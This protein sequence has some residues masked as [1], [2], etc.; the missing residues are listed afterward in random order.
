MGAQAVAG[1]VALRVEPSLQVG[2]AMTALS[3]GRR[4]AFRTRQ[5]LARKRLVLRT[6]P[7]M[8]SRTSPPAASRICAS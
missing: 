1:R 7:T 3:I 6:R 4:S 5:S 2:D 8:A